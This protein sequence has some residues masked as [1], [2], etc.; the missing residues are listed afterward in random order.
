MTPAVRARAMHAAGVAV[1]PGNEG[2]DFVQRFV[3]LAEEAGDLEVQYTAMTSLLFRHLIDGRRAEFDEAL[4]RLASI[5]RELR[6]PVSTVP[7]T[8]TGR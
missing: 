3:A 6:S 7:W 4:D 1:L 2:L 8:S 5:A